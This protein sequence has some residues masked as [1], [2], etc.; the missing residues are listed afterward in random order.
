MSG[1]G[2]TGGEFSDVVLCC[3]AVSWLSD[4]GDRVRE[5]VGAHPVPLV[6]RSPCSLLPVGVVF[7]VRHARASDA[8]HLWIV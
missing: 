6:Q 2:R 4:H 3:E 7:E 1:A 8:K 5:T